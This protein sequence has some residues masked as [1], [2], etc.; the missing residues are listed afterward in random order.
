MTKTYWIDTSTISNYLKAERS[1]ILNDV[2]SLRMIGNVK[3]E[4]DQD[5]EVFS[6]FA[7]ARQKGAFCGEE[8]LRDDVAIGYYSDLLDALQDG[9]AATIAAARVTREGICLDDKPGVRIAIEDRHVDPDFVMHSVR[10]LAIWCS[11]DPAA[12]E[13][14][15]NDIIDYW[16]RHKF[17]TGIDH[18]ADM[19]SCVVER[20]RTDAEKAIYSKWVKTSRS[21]EA[22]Q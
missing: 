11:S 13:R 10:V 15:A 5:K 9:E 18:V 1:H 4:L 2:I 12:R 6:L 8:D 14:E 7:S 22:N 21:A 3:R 19:E 17:E 20:C 16:N